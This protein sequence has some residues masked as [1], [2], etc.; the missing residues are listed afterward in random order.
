MTDATVD[1]LAPEGVLRVA[2]NTGNFLLVSGRD[3]EGR[4]EGVAPALGA[5]LARRLGLPLQFVEYASP[6][7]LVD[8]APA[9]QW[10]VG[11]VGADPAR[12]GVLAFTEPYVEI[13]ATFLV[14]GESPARTCAELD[15]SGV[16]ISASSR[17]A[18]HLWLMANF[19]HAELRTAQGLEASFRRFADEKLDALAGL[20]TRLE[21]DAGRLPGARVLPGR[22]MAV[23]QAACTF[24]ERGEG[25]RLLSDFIAQMKR[26]GELA[27]II[28]SFGQRGKLLVAP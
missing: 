20:R 9:R 5:A 17:S 26:G 25:M 7:E 27:R 8:S 12:T 6:G 10:D 18:Y 16:T 23:Q 22:F 24:R 15:A 14:P 19:S 13:E 28:E 11:F 21:H 4:P 1:D 3:A 2:L